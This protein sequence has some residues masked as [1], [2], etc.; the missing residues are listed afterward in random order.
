MVTRKAK[1]L[2]ALSTAALIV[3][4]CGESEPNKSYKHLPSASTPS[5][6]KLDEMLHYAALIKFDEG[7]GITIQAD[8]KITDDYGD[9]VTDMDISN[10][11]EK[12]LKK[13]PAYIKALEEFNNASPFQKE[14]AANNERVIRERTLER[15]VNQLKNERL[16]QFRA[17]QAAA[18]K[19]AGKI[20]AQDIIA[21]RIVY[22]WKERRFLLHTETPQT[23]AR[24]AIHGRRYA[25]IKMDTEEEAQQFNLLIQEK[26]SSPPREGALNCQALNVKD[27]FDFLL[28]I[29][30]RGP[31][32]IDTLYIWT[33]TWEGPESGWM[34]SG[35]TV[36][37]PRYGR[38]SP[39]YWFDPTQRMTSEQFRNALTGIHL[40]DLSYANE[41]ALIKK[42]TAAA[43]PKL[44]PIF[45][46]TSLE[47]L[48]CNGEVLGEVKDNRFVPKRTDPKGPAPQERRAAP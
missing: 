30:S 37:K 31:I 5:K 47:I 45:Q 19:F 11:A 23:E 29:N 15:L 33:T 7:I 17:K 44:A 40:A 48:G 43:D 34:I 4:G 24:Y 21:E 12:E 28:R 38:Y 1:I 35:G 20:I 39:S 13:D 46:I 26:K 10:L 6:E 2:A 36:D 3:T 42:I 16:E 25:S 22:D 18:E 32:G 8:L 27:N 9:D 14:A 41:Q